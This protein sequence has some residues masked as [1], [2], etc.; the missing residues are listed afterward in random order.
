MTETARRDFL[1]AMRRATD[2]A[3]LAMDRLVR[4]MNF[5]PG[6]SGAVTLEAQREIIL[7]VATMGELVAE[8][9]QNQ[10]EFFTSPEF[11]AMVERAMR[12]GADRAFKEAAGQTR[13]RP[14]HFAA[15][16][17]SAVIFLGGMSIKAVYDMVYDSAYKTAYSAG[18]NTA[19]MTTM[20]D[21]AN[22]PRPMAPARERACALMAPPKLDNPIPIGIEPGGGQDAPPVFRYA[23][24]ASSASPVAPR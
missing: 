10:E 12:T 4:E 18:Y 11:S 1:G 5:R 23:S 20:A 24:P 7:A 15:V 13:R 9:R 3:L 16:I 17:I 19:L 8:V 2:G 22:D 14:T 21:C 6:S